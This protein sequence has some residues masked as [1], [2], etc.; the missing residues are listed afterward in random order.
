MNADTASLSAFDPQAR[1]DALRQCVAGVPP[2]RCAVVH[3]CDAE[4]LAGALDAGAAGLIVPL[5][6]GPRARIEEAA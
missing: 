4:S 6:V 1:L 3:P 2:V 5:L